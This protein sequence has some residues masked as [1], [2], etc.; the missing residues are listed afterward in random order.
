MAPQH[1]YEIKVNEHAED[2]R[3]GRKRVVKPGKGRSTSA[4]GGSVKWTKEGLEGTE[5]PEETEETDSKPPEE[6]AR[7]E[8]PVLKQI[9]KTWVTG[10]RCARRV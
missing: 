4:V 2:P 3:G 7:F 10:A 9:I 1:K 8:T 5:E 6:D